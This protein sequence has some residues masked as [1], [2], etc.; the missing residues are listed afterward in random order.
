MVK[1]RVDISIDANIWEEAKRFGINRSRIC[2]EAIGTQINLIKGDVTIADKLLIKSKLEKR[3][4]ELN[5]VQSEVSVLRNQLAQIE[6]LEVEHR[7]DQLQKDKEDIENA[8]KC[9]NCNFIIPDAVKM[10]TF[11]AGQV[12][13][14]CFLAA[15]GKEFD[16][17]NIIKKGV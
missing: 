8:R 1:A 6:K 15:H 14:N 10:H 12:C 7:E 3:Q 9:I 17:W 13:N 16:K 5:K 4:S 2:E 11:P